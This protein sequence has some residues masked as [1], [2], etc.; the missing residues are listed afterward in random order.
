MSPLVPLF[1]MIGIVLPMGVHIG[2]PTNMLLKK[3]CMYVSF[4]FVI[5]VIVSIFFTKFK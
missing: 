1:L 3:R 4:V 2:D 5:L